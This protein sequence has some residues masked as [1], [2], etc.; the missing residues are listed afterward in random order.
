MGPHDRLDRARV[1]Y[2]ALDFAAAEVELNEARAGSGQLTSEQRH[3]VFVLSAQTA[4]A[5]ERLA[6]ARVHLDALLDLDPMFAPAENAWSPQWLALLDAVRAA[7][8]DGE[9]PVVTV[10]PPQIAAPGEPLLIQIDA[11]DPS[12]IAS[13]T[14]IIGDRELAMTPLT[15]NSWGVRLEG[16]DVRAP[17]V[18]LQVVAID[19]RKNASA[20]KHVAIEVAGPTSDDDGLT[21]RWWFWA[22][23]GVVVVGGGAAGVAVASSGSDGGTVRGQVQWP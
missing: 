20:P 23:L 4:M 1:A 2:A 9:G 5:S 17:S 16:T 13:A 15:G 8:P 12:G 10:L 19:T 21:S 7:R 11:Q 18:Q 3:E 14:V 22:A 6:D